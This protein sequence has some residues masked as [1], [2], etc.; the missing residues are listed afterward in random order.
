MAKLDNVEM[1]ATYMSLCGMEI[2]L[3]GAG[4][5]GG[6]KNNSELKYL[7]YKNPMHSLDAD[8]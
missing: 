6:I 7:N 1:V 2:A 3:I 8:I 4:V 5:D